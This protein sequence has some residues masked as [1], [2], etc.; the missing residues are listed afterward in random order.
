MATLQVINKLEAAADFGSTVAGWKT[1]L[2]NCDCHTFD[3]V[4]SLLIEATGCSGARATQLANI[5]HHTGSAVVYRGTQAECEK[6]ATI[7]GKTG[8]KVSVSW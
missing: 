3:D 8:L 1:T 6:T 7:L 4:I 5:V 2:F